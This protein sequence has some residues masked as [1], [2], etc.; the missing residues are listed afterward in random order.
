M[1]GMDD[2]RLLARAD[3]A[4]AIAVGGI[5]A[6]LFAAALWFTWHF[7]ATLFLIFAGMLL[8][9]GLSAMAGLLGRV[10]RLPQPIRLAI[11]CLTLAILLS[12]VLVLGGATIAQQGTA[13]S[14][15][16]KSQ[17]A[18]VKS[19]LKFRICAGIL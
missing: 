10:I 11:V 4:W 14:N 19:F 6:V 7:A 17:L 8:G 9:L 12:G 16:I 15:T 5:S 18:N 2:Q 1:T 3:L 13:L